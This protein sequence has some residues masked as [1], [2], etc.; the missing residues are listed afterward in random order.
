MIFQRGAVTERFI[1]DVA[2][3]CFDSDVLHQMSFQVVRRRKPSTAVWTVIGVETFVKLQVQLE[4]E[5]G[6]EMFA[7]L[8]TP[9]SRSRSSPV[10][11]VV[12]YGK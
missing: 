3:E 1:A 11:G 6:S 5:V 4:S 8:V 7:T 2:H 12:A 10:P 9:A